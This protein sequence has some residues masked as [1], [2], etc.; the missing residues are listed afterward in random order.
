VNRRE[1]EATD[2]IALCFLLFNPFFDVCVNN[3]RHWPAGA[4]IAEQE[5]IWTGLTGLTG[6]S[7]ENRLSECT[8]HPV[9]PVNPVKTLSPPGL[10]C[11]GER[12]AGRPVVARTGDEA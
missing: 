6:F 10:H 8:P 1:R 11:Q 12:G 2:G 3:K 7:E 5:G 4:G 9:N